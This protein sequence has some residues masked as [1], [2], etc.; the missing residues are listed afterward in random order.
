[1]PDVVLAIAKSP[2]AI[3][4]CF[5]PKDAGQ[6]D[7]ESIGV[8]MLFDLL[9]Q[10]F[11]HFGPGFQSMQEGVVM[12]YARG[13]SGQRRQDHVQQRGRDPCRVRDGLV[14]EHRDRDARTRQVAD[15]V[16]DAEVAPGMAERSVPSIM[17]GWPPVTRLRI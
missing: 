10:R 4:P 12:E 17:E 13:A 15:H 5:A 6:G 16:P 11:G 3:F 1:M 2:F 9:R 8:K 14:R 7:E